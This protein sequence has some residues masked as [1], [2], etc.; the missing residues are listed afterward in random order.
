MELKI[1]Q[2]DTGQIYSNDMGDDNKHKI[3]EIHF[4]TSYTQIEVQSTV[5]G[6]FSHHSVILPAFG[7]KAEGMGWA[8]DHIATQGEAEG[9]WI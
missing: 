3:I 4:C 9:E 8:I 7:V 5:E 2:K 6:I 1:R